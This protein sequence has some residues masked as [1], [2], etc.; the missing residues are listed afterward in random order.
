MQKSNQIEV[1]FAKK[2]E[3]IVDE[4]NS[5]QLCW[6]VDGFLEIQDAVTLK[7]IPHLH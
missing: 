6:F 5:F 1:S 2:S 3:E 7:I 4:A